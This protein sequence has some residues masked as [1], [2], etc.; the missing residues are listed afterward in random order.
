MCKY[1]SSP[2][3]EKIHIMSNIYDYILKYVELAIYFTPFS[4]SLGSWD[5]GHRQSQIL[6]I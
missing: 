2:T 5:S 3:H 4:I 1:V 6:R